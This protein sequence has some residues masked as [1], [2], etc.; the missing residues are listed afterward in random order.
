MFLNVNKQTSA[1]TL[2][3]LLVH[4]YIDFTS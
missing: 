3:Y 4:F 2:L 1:S